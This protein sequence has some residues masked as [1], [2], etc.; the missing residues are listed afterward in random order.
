VLY[1]ADGT[2]SPALGTRGGH[3]GG[4]LQAMKR[5]V[6]GELVSLPACGGVRLAPGETVVSVASGGGG[7]GSPLDRDP[8]RVKADVDEGWITRGRARDIYGV[9]FDSS[10]NVDPAATQALRERLALQATGR[11]PSA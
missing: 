9:T 10:G 7:Y 2:V 6:S 5:L 3:A 4:L 8:A 11:T 1:T